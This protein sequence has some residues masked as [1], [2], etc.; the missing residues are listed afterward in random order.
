MFVQFKGEQAHAY[1]E[2][3]VKGSGGDVGG[4]SNRV[5]DLER[6]LR[7]RNEE[8]RELRVS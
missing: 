6:Q 2:E 5:R 3:L 7:E 1:F 4:A 8:I